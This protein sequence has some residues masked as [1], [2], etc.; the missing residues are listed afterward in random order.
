MKENLK[1]YLKSLFA[2][3]RDTARNS[4]LFEELLGN[5]QDRYD[6]LIAE[7]QSPADAYAKAI[8]EL[9]DIT[10]LIEKNEASPAASE[11][12][13]FHESAEEKRTPP[14]LGKKKQLSAEAL[15][16][17]KHSLGLSVAIA[18]ML[19]IFWLVPTVLAPWGVVFLFLFVAVAT[20]M[21]ILNGNRIPPYVDD[22]ALTYGEELREQKTRLAHILI[23]LGVGLCILSI[24]PVVLIQSEWGVAL[25]FT[26]ITLGVGAIVYGS[27]IVPTADSLANRPGYQPL[28]GENPPERGE[29]KPNRWLVPIILTAAALMICSCIWAG[30]NGMSFGLFGIE[31]RPLAL[32]VNEGDASVE[33]TLEQLDI[34]WTAGS[35]RLE[36]YEGSTV[37]LVETQHGQPVPAGEER[38]RWYRENGALH[39][40]FDG[41]SDIRFYWGKQPQKDLVVRIPA[42]TELSSVALELV[43]AK[44]EADGL[45]VT[46]GAGVL[47]IDTVSGAI[48][49]RG[50]LANKA[51]LDAVSAIQILT[52]CDLDVLC[53][54]TVSGNVTLQSSTVGRVDFTGISAG[55]ASNQCVHGIVEIDTT[56]G[57][58]D[59]MVGAALRQIEFDTTSG[60]ME[61]HL[62]ADVTGFTARLDSTSGD[63]ECSLA[64]S[65]RNG[66]HVYGDGALQIEMDS[67][68]GDLTVMG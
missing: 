8:G 10:P 49:L 11:A 67:T 60:D 27:Y 43:S 6:E 25:M 48:L 14:P 54:D 19:Y 9:G 64:T 33:M 59:I 5:L 66:A 62:E 45:L 2:N 50:V 47:D 29:K 55:F 31:G 15:C 35:V 30:F 46:E 18:V 22:S 40:R 41:R 20:S 3:A 42:Q 36:Y 44:L 53:V 52:D 38:M 32:Y 34:Q 65:Y 16:R 26:A 63:F 57:D 24:I 13:I 17:A 28:Q 37:E 68:S 23:A 39:V 56:S 51:D 61:L 58:V 21:L 7:G 1:L 4:A 12:Q